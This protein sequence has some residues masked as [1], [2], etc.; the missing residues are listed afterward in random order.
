MTHLRL[1]NGA[2]MEFSTPRLARRHAA[3]HHLTGAQVIRDGVLLSTTV[4]MPDLFRWN[5]MEPTGGPGV[6]SMSWTAFPRGE[7]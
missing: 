5:D 1:P 7:R 3:R 4:S 2:T 6:P